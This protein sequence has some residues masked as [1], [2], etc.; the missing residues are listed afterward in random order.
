MEQIK[1][2]KE[3]SDNI[4]EQ[5]SIYNN[6]LRDIEYGSI[7]VD[8]EA[9]KIASSNFVKY[10]SSRDRKTREQAYFVVNNVFQKEEDTNYYL[11]AFFNVQERSF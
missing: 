6:L 2:I 10:I 5:L 1:K 9:I 4:N 3:N 8:R 11:I 7:N